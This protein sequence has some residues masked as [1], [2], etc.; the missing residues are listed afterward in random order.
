VVRAN[1]GR[2]F[3]RNLLTGAAQVPEKGGIFT[4]SAFDVT[5]P[6]LGSDY[7]DS[8][9]DLVITSGFPTG[10]G[11]RSPAENPAYARFAN[12]LRRDPLA[13]YKLLGIAVSNPSAPPVVNADNIQSLSGLSPAQA[14]ALLERTY[15]GT[16]FEFFDVPGGSIVGNR[17]LSFFPRGPLSVTRDV[18]R[19]SEDRTPM[20][21]AFS[22][23]FEQ[24]F[25]KDFGASVTYVHRRGRDLLTRRI[26]NLY[27]VPQGN[28]NFG[29]TTDGGSRIN[30]F[31]YD[32]RIE[33]DG[34]AVAV[35]KRYSHGYAF[36]VSYTYSH[37]D[38]NLL[39]GGVGSGFSNN[40]HPEIDF[41]PSNQSVPSNLT[42]SGLVDLPLGF[43]LSGI[44]SWRSGIAFN[45]RGIQD[46]DGDGLVDQRDTAV[47]RNSFRTKA[48]RTFDARLEK[49]FKISHRNE[50]S[51]LVEGFNIFNSGNV[52]NITDVS[53]A[54]FGTPTEY[55]PGREIQFGV[56]WRFGR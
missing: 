56:R 16:D 49:G 46:L 31:T 2:F 5:L 3:D 17:V 14:L 45:P 27:D 30:Q 34:I 9:I 48:Y 35:R 53:G 42:A 23:G 33:Y 32:G 8:L 7:T 4:R 54:S 20:T 40:N 21:D 13:L 37:N 11:T 15:P 47:P 19:Y 12:D 52:K 26:V 10:P 39:T 6:R 22:I 28:P 43:K 25:L 36:L 51:A 29:R 41:G 38:D 55:F 50:L 44:F 18:S 24:E 1:W